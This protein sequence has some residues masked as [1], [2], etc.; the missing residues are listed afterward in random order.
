MVENTFGQ[1]YHLALGYQT[2]K[3]GGQGPSGALLNAQSCLGDDIKQNI[4]IEAILASPNLGWA[5]RQVLCED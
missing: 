3:R 1:L 5:L 2:E 4:V